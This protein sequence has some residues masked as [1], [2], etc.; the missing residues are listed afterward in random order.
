MKNLRKIIGLGLMSLPVLAMM[1]SYYG[2][3][4]QENAT[5]W[6]VGMTLYLSGIWL[7]MGS[8]KK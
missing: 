7:V 6:Y 1:F 8:D 3:I 2:K 5:I 4:G